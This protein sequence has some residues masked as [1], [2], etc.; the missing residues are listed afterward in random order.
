MKGGNMSG[1]NTGRVILGGLLAGLVVNV[2]EFILNTF[3]IDEERMTEVYTAMNLDPP[4]GSAIAIFVVFG[5][6]IGITTVW[7]YAAARPRLG[8]GP[9]SAAIA[10]IPIWIAGFLLPLVG[11]VV[12][13][14]FPTNLAILAGVWGLA[15]MISAAIAGAWLYTEGEASGGAAAA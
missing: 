3:V 15:E 4:G 10:A 14:M 2:G 12:Q 1:I 6:V 13:G 5:F 7:V 8:P 11:Y 9:K